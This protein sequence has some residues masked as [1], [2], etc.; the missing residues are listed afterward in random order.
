MPQVLSITPV[1]PCALGVAGIPKREVP[2]KCYV[3]VEALVMIA[4]RDGYDG[5]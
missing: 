5:H 2:D 1:F 4:Y 3:F